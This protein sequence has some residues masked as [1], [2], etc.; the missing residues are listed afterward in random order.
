MEVLFSIVRLW[1]FSLEFPQTVTMFV[2]PVTLF[3]YML[4]LDNL[5]GNYSTGDTGNTW[6]PWG[7]F[8]PLESLERR[9]SKPTLKGLL[10]FLPRVT[11][12]TVTSLEETRMRVVGVRRG[13]NSWLMTFL[14]LPPSKITSNCE[15]CRNG[16]EKVNLGETLS[17]IKCDQGSRYQVNEPSLN[18]SKY[19]GKGKDFSPSIKNFRWVGGEINN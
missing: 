18:L 13:R 2:A 15:M 5:F 9:N 17:V 4:I 12:K 8:L 6:L 7:S 16:N 1:S 14:S 11:G 3:L 19:D 10:T